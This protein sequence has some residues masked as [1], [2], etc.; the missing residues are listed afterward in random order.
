MEPHP[1]DETTVR[2]FI[3]GKAG[4]SVMDSYDVLQIALQSGNKEFF[5]FTKVIKPFRSDRPDGKPVSLNDGDMMFVTNTS[6]VIDE[7][8][9]FIEYFYQ[10]ENF[11]T[12][13]KAN[14]VIPIYNSDMDSDY[15]KATPLFVELME[16][17]KY[18]GELPATPAYRSAR[19]YLADE[20]EKAIYSG[21]SFKDT[22]NRSEEVWL[23]EIK[24]LQ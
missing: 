4:I 13:A 9:S 3:A 17:Q 6:E 11:M 10:P 22:L 19:A 24:E 8:W 15:V 18:G 21:Q 16:M 2:A 20:I 7:A 5:E 12:Y 14:K 23:R 1:L